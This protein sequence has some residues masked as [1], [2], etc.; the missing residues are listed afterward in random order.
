MTQDSRGRVTEPHSPPRAVLQTVTEKPARGNVP[1]SSGTSRSIKS[2]EQRPR[3]STPLLPDLVMRPASGK[4]EHHLLSAAEL[5]GSAAR[6]PPAIRVIHLD[7]STI[8]RVASIHG[9]EPISS[10]TRARRHRPSAITTAAPARKILCGRRNTAWCAARL[11][12]SASRPG[13]QRRPSRCSTWTTSCLGQIHG[14][15]QYVWPGSS[16]LSGFKCHAERSSKKIIQGSGWGGTFK[17]FRQAIS[18]RSTTACV[19]ASVGLSI[20]AATAAMQATKPS[21]PP[22]TRSIVLSYTM[23]LINVN[24][25]PL[26]LNP[27]HDHRFGRKGK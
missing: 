6:D 20:S 5:L 14:R 3:P 9:G 19:H 8:C 23:R 21:A 17:Y 13:T 26:S 10:S 18:H 2:A 1:A 24:Y 25:F 7:T 4:Q 12:G 27:E 16:D 22:R 11:Y 15:S